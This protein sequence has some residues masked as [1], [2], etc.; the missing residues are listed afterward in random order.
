[1]A[2]IGPHAMPTYL[3]GAAIVHCAG[4]T[5]ARNI[6]SEVLAH[7]GHAGDADVDD[8]RHDLRWESEGRD[9][10]VYA[11]RYKARPLHALPLRRTCDSIMMPPSEPRTS[12]RAYKVSLAKL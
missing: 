9:E 2:S 12:R 1:M 4:E 6:Q 3:L 10:I 7:H 8:A 11:A 5:L